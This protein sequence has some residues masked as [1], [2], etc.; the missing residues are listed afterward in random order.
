MEE[1]LKEF[2][3]RYREVVKETLLLNKDCRNNV[4]SFS[5]EGVFQKEFV[6]SISSLRLLIYSSYLRLNPFNLHLIEWIKRF[7]AFKYVINNS[8]KFISNGYDDRPGEY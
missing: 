3:G 2:L 5:K 7:F 4:S 8:N 6:N 1:F